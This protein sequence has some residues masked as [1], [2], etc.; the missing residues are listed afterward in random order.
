MDFS[1][2]TDLRQLAAVLDP[3][4]RSTKVLDIP[5]LLIGAAARDLL[6]HHMR[7]W[8]PSRRTEDVDIAILVETWEEFAR[9]QAMLFTAEG[10]RPHPAIKQRVALP[11]GRVDIVPCGGVERSGAIE[12]PPDGNPRLDVLG[13][14]EAIAGAVCVTLPGPL[15]VPVV[16]LEGYLCLKLFA[17]R[18]R[19]LRKP[20]HDAVDLGDLLRRAGDLI[21]ID[22]LYRD[23]LGDL[24]V[25]DFDPARA[26]LRLMGRRLRD[27]LAP[28]AT[29]ALSEMLWG[30]LDE[31]GRLELVRE[32]R[33]V[34]GAMGLLMALLGGLQSA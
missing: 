12:W 32:L 4:A 13:L 31:D 25:A 3:V 29:A 26:T 8:P 2:A 1:S 9:L 19:H 27:S 22:V 28:P 10:G 16:S 15:S 34:P 20:M 5:W 17:W 18:D 14:R 24:E 7:G 21:E 30:E 23:H 33:Q 6:L 11:T